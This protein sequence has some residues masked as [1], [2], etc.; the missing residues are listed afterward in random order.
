MDKVKIALTVLSILIILV[1]LAVEVYDYRD[2]LL[3][4]I[5]PPA[6]KSVVNGDLGSGA[7]TSSEASEAINNFQIPQPQ[8][9]QLQYNPT[10]GAFSFP[11]NFTNPL[12]TDLSFNQLSAEVTTEDGQPLGNV[13]VP[14][15]INIEPGEN[16]MVVAQGFLSQ[17]AIN[18]IVGN[19]T[20]GNLST[21]NIALSNVNVDVGGVM[22]HID[23]IDAGQIQTDLSALTNQNSGATP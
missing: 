16:A 9:G 22:V 23:H 17:S 8:A 15:T 20:S 7:Q 6:L 11:F 18:Q 12:N 2:N 1:P 19:Y 13:S 10:T 5:L 4:L 3:G 14:Q 21:L